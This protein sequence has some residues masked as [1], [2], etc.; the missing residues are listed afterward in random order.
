M[1]L[2]GEH[3]FE[4]PREL[5]WKVISD[6]AQMAE[7]MPGVQSFDVADDHHFRKFFELNLFIERQLTVRGYSV[8][9]RGGFNNITG[10]F[11]PNVVD[12]V[13]GGPTY[14]REYGGQARALNFRL[15]YL[16]HR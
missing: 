8:A 11:N 2:E 7:L 9:V 14:L 13:L 6:P 3:S 12:N 1:R 15:R 5:V 10:H 4:A 16:G